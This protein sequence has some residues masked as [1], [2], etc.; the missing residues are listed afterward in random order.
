[1]AL[2]SIWGR[3]GALIWGPFGVSVQSV[4]GSIWGQFGVDLASIC[5]QFG[6]DLGW[7]SGRMR[8]SSGSIG[9]DSRAQAFDLGQPRSNFSR[10]W[11]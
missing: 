7:I 4:S 5:S 3:R 11:R 2:G 1:M 8:G 9:V 6:I 10:I